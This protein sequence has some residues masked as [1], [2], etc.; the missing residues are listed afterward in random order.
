MQNCFAQ[1]S[2]FQENSRKLNE[3]IKELSHD[4]IARLQLAWS[5]VSV[6]VCVCL[7]VC[8][9]KMNALQKIPTFFQQ[10]IT[11]YLLM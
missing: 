8:V 2:A 5:C 11:V 1:T 9:F 10:I 4:S 3:E 7:C 6:C